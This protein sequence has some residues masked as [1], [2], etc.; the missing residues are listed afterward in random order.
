MLFI[1]DEEGRRVDGLFAN[2]DRHERGHKSEI[3]SR[4]FAPSKIEEGLHTLGTYSII[5]VVSPST[6]PIPI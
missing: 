4:S 2:I 3:Q 1:D 6:P 5:R